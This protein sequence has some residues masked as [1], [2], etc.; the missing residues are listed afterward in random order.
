M[1]DKLYKCGNCG[2]VMTS[3][4]D[5]DNTRVK[6]PKCGMQAYFDSSGDEH[7]TKRG[8]SQS[9]FPRV[10]KFALIAVL[11]ILIIAIVASGITFIPAGTEGVV[12]KFGAVTNQTI[13]AGGH[14]LIPVEYSVQLINIRTI[15]FTVVTNAPT[16]DLQSVDTEVTLD[17]AIPATAVN[18]LYKTL[19]LGYQAT[20]ISPILQETV[21]AVEANFTAENLTV[22]RPLV[23]S[24][25]QERLTQTL[26]KY[27]ISVQQLS[28]VNFS[29]TPQFNA[30]IDNKTAAQQQL[31]Q[32][33]IEL[34]TTQVYAQQRE[35][36]AYGNSSARIIQ[37]NG[38]AR[39]AEII[40]NSLAGN[41]LYLK[42][43]SI[44]EWNGKLPYV[45]S[46]SGALPL[47]NLNTSSLNNT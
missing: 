17:Y 29:Y 35:A 45:V 5:G 4:K 34:N 44:T 13:S 41:P 2:A 6:C 38:T 10:G 21:K 47:I 33:K 9:A 32:A 26:I 8:A 7:V 46:S 22:E 12:L 16:H 23:Q 1:A 42:Y 28:L 39:A 40:Q 37:A 30:A 36:S 14:Y 20:I 25:I 18:P 19:G 43:I 27:N 31:L 3:T 15:A 24:E 11:A